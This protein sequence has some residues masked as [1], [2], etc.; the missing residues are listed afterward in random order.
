MGKVKDVYIKYGAA[1][2]QHVGRV[3]AGLPV[4]KANYA[5]SPPFFRVKKD[6]NV[7]PKDNECTLADID[8]GIATLFPTFASKITFKPVTITCAAALFYAYSHLEK[9][10]PAK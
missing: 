2:D 6:L 1:G 9:N 3:I 5:V 7:P 10:M 8:Y 4:L